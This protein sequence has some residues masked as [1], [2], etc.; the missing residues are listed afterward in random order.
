METQKPKI[1]L[2]VKR[3]FGEK[4]TA[5]FGFVNENWK[6]LL[7]YT[8][9]LIL[10][11]CLIQGLS[12][13]SFMQSYMGVVASAG[14][15]I[16]SYDDLAYTLGV[17]Y[18][19]LILLSMIGGLILTSLVYGLIK[20][21]NE[22]EERLA[23]V[24]FADLKPLLFSNA[25]R[26]LILWL[27][28]TAIVFGAVVVMALLIVITPWTMLLTIPFLIACI[29]P[30]TLLPSIYLF[31]NIGVW[32]AFLKTFRLGFATWGGIFGVTFV[33]GF[34]ANVVQGV[35]SIPYM[36]VM[37]VGVALTTSGMQ[38]EMTTSAGFG[39]MNYLF[40]VLMT[41][42]IYLSMI[43]TMLGLVYQYGHA[44]E[45][46]DSISVEEDINRFEQL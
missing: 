42:G 35:L 28:M 5:T 26:L 13:K 21:Y 12:M 41:F 44:C 40:A 36:V 15:G 20:L 33:T 38:T 46:M 43:F 7:K 14:N 10:P 27:F 31:E 16:S 11:L 3:S 30:L 9:Y 29:F 22:R 25:K 45:V 24:T 4:L 39:F 2:Y 18:G 23:G 17:S 19:A 1:A 32:Q 34:I 37:V 6:V 8:T